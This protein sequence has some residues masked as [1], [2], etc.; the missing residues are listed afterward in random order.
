V[1][2]GQLEESMRHEIESYLEGRL[3]GIKQEISA[4]QSQ[5]NE[6]LNRLLDRQGDVQLDGAVAAS[7]LDHL[8]SAHEAGIDLAASE[9]GHAKASSEMAIVK[10]AISEID[11]QDSQANILK[12]LVNR[13]AAFAPRVAFFVVKGEQSIGWRARGFEGTVGDNAIHQMK[14]SLA[15]DTAV[16]SAARTRTSWSGG[17]GSHSE[18]HLIINRLGDEP[19]ARIVAIPLVVRKRAVAVLYA[20][21]GGL[22][23]EAINLEAIETLVRV[24]GMA[25]E[26]LAGRSTPAQASAAPQPATEEPAPA[27]EPESYEQPGYQPAAEY[28]E[29]TPVVEESAPA[30]DVSEVGP[31][32][33]A[34]Q[35]EA[36]VEPQTD[37]QPEAEPQSESQFGY[38]AVEDAPV[39]EAS[40][41]MPVET[42]PLAEETAAPAAPRRRYGA[43]V[44]LPVEVAGEEER[45]LH[46]DARRFARLL[47][48]EIKLYNE[49]KVSEGRSQGDLYPRLREYIDRSREMYDKRVKP[50]V[51]Q[52]YDYFHHELVGTLAEGDEAKLGGAYPGATVSA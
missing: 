7:I 5:L 28:D 39:S 21:S 41:E 37:F 44:E 4:L 15:A 20:D 24:S 25:V 42:A 11:E 52:R 1:V 23:S 40:A 27:P 18:D 35:A 22:D 46:N 13:A 48:S 12:I 17:P 16:G 29:L 36:E 10:A 51:A 30:A 8:R 45:R 34:Y 32:P 47:V 2:S 33:A 31:E 14:F 26:L 3:S 9:S 19:P 49:Q 6:S 50:E 38:S 43:D